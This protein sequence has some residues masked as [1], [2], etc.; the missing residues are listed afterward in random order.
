MSSF[1][2]EASDF[3]LVSVHP[4]QNLLRASNKLKTTSLSRQAYKAKRVKL[5]L[6]AI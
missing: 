3:T 6:S 1:M 5:Q 2:N 4:A